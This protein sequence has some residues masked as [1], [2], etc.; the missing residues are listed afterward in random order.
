MAGCLPVLTG[1]FP[2]RLQ[3]DGD[4]F[5]HLI[6]GVELVQSA[7]EPMNHT[8][9]APGVDRDSR[10]LQTVGIAL[11]LIAKRIKFGRNHH[12]GGEST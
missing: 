3:R 1:V 7:G 11:A 8:R 4:G 12:S 2:S 6:G 9:I 10:G 5:Q